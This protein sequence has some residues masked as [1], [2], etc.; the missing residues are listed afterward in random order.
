MNKNSDLR[1]VNDFLGK[2]IGVSQSTPTKACLQKKS[3]ELRIELKFAE[4]TSYH[5]L[6]VALATG[7][8]DAFSADKSILHG[9]QDENTVILND[10]ICKQ[11][12]GAACKLENK[13]FCEYLNKIIGEIKNE[14]LLENLIKK[15]GLESNGN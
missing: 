4:Y 13:V 6:K 7:R 9:Y 1:S 5:E 10:V 8:I 15:W 3:Q 2:I 12:Y 14:G 11:D